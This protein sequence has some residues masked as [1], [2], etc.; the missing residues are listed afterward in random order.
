MK[1]KILRRANIIAVIGS[2]QKDN[3]MKIKADIAYNRPVHSK[4]K[5]NFLLSLKELKILIE[6]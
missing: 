3:Y 1:H 2:N 4:R 5:Q 6:G